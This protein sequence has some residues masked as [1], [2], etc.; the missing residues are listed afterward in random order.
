MLLHNSLKPYKTRATKPKG[1]GKLTTAPKLHPEAPTR[2]CRGQFT[3]IHF[4][5]FFTLNSRKQLHIVNKQNKVESFC[6]LFGSSTALETIHSVWISQRRRIKEIDGMVLFVP[7]QQV[8]KGL[9]YILPQVLLTETR[10][11][12][13]K[14]HSP[15]PLSVLGRSSP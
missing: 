4:S 10:V 1:T 2:V 5:F 13:V 6:F 3:Q 11:D 8:V 7:V 14:Y 12:D 15:R 9:V